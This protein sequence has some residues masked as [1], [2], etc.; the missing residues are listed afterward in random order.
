MAT[1]STSTAAIL[2][3][4]VTS[5]M[6]V[7]NRERVVVIAPLVE[8]LHENTKARQATFISD[9]IDSS[10]TPNVCTF[11][12]RFQYPLIIALFMARFSLLACAGSRCEN[13]HIRAF[14]F[15]SEGKVVPLPG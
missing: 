4:A 15:M 1:C 10:L 5:P 13:T 7:A 11:N 6:I 3:V 8:V 14:Y 2:P 12:V 9:P